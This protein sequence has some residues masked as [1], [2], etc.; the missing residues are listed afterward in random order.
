MIRWSA[1]LLLFICPLEAF[2]QPKLEG[3]WDVDRSLGAQGHEYADPAFTDEGQRR[4]DA[5]SAFSDDPS[6]RCIPSGLGRAWD[7]P[8]TAFEIRQFDDRVVIRYEMFD[9]IRTIALNQRGHPLDPVAST[10]NIPG[11]AMP[12]MGHSIGWYEGDALVV[13]TLNYAP[14]YITTLVEISGHL[15]PQSEALRTQER[16]FRDGERMAVEITYVDPI[17]L[18]EPLTVRYKFRKSPFEMTE[19]GCIAE[20][21][22]R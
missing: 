7:E 4:A 14:G 5:Y 21:A 15:I 13:E 17:I 20:N 6:V 18:A 8:D 22:D 12:T 19:Y 2:A 11:V 10:V 3:V 9:L 1:L 16:I